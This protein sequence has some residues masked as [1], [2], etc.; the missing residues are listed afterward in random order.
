MEIDELR[1]N[2][3]AKTAT[4]ESTPFGPDT[5]VFKVYNKMFCLCNISDF[6]SVNLKRNPE[7]AIELREQYYA[8]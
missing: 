6:K 3:L 2:C 8:V 1:D 7:K 5:L 4:A